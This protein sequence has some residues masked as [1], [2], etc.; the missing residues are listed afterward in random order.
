MSYDTATESYTQETTRLHVEPLA[1]TAATE[2][3]AALPTWAMFALLVVV[4]LLVLARLPQEAP[5]AAPAGPVI[6]DSFNRTCVLVV[7]CEP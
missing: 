6:T 1:L 3:R 4:L 7:R 2:R 5:M